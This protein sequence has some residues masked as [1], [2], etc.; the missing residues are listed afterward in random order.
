[1]VHSNSCFPVHVPSER[2]FQNDKNDGLIVTNKP[3]QLYSYSLN[4]FNTDPSSN[5]CALISPCVSLK[6][7]LPA[8]IIENY[9][10]ATYSSQFQIAFL[11]LQI[12]MKSHPG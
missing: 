3:T 9:V 10:Q 6:A 4:V 1:M 5:N 2:Y 7:S 8:G 11:I 12:I